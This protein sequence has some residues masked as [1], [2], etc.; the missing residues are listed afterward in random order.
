MMDRQEDRAIHYIHDPGKWAL[1]DAYRSLPQYGE[2]RISTDSS[3]LFELLKLLESIGFCGIFI[4]AFDQASTQID[5][6]AFK[7]KNGPCYDTGRTAKYT[8][9]ALAAMDD[10]NHLLIKDFELSVCEKTARIYSLST[11]EGFITVSKPDEQLLFKLSD[12]PE[13]FNCDDFDASQEKLYSELR[14]IQPS[15]ERGKLYY[16]GP[17]KLL[18]LE[19]GSVVRRGIFNSVPKNLVTVLN[20]RE[21]LFVW[22][23]EQD[24]NSS[25]YQYEYEKNGPAILLSSD[26][27]QKT[28][29]NPPE[30]DFSSL[31]DLPSVFRDRLKHTITQNKKY[32]ILSGTDPADELG[33]CPSTEVKIA[34]KLVRAGILNAFSQP[35]PA[36]ACPVTLYSF[37]D[38]SRVNGGVLESEID[39][40]FRA[41]VLSLLSTSANHLY[42][43][44]LQWGLLLFVVCSII[45]GLTRIL[46]RE[47]NN[48]EDKFA[49]LGLGN[50]STE[51]LLFH[52]QKR[53][54]QCLNLE[55][56]LRDYILKYN[57]QADAQKL[58]LSLI[59]MNN[60]ENYHLIE[61][62]QIYSATPVILKFKDAHPEDV[63]VLHNAW[64]KYNDQEAFERQFEEALFQV[65]S[66]KDE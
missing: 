14:N 23:A 46:S 52:N 9:I 42:R 60:P 53:C 3:N 40:G 34:N 48:S 8:G 18:I 63:R 61:E 12:N 64:K 45:L 24:V 57:R 21:G 36:D 7:G 22:E 58:K 11:Y 51:I 27:S 56:Y 32:F 17:F 66:S 44:V 62:F 6:R 20:N 38:E 31:K 25:F 19:D 33:C 16:P 39:D 59:N 54:V 29:D 35:V 10:D 41:E 2:I 43:R 5:I 28:T 47:I 1:D 15:N 37:R 30:S 55:K 4:S 49:Y 26:F 13:P 65:I 50:N